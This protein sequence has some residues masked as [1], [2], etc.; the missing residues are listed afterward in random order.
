MNP[1]PPKNQLL[2]LVCHYGIIKAN[3]GYNCLLL[4]TAALPQAKTP[5]EAGT[6]VQSQVWNCYIY[7]G[8]AKVGGLSF[9]LF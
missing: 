7:I 3:C 2:T 6:A 9:H 1:P 8:S 5:A 4:F